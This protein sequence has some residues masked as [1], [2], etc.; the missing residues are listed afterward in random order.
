MPLSGTLIKLRHEENKTE[1][2]STPRSISNSKPAKNL[3]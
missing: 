2:F 3:I 1:K